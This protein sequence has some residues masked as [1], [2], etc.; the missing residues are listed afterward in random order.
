LTS[1]SANGESIQI[2]PGQVLPFFEKKQDALLGHLLVNEQF[3]MQARTKIRAEW[4]NDP[5]SGKVWKFKQNFFD[6][7]QRCPSVEEFKGTLEFLRE[8]MGMRNKLYAKITIAQV[9][10]KE[11]GLDVI[12]NELTLWL[13][14]Q[15]AKAYAEKFSQLYNAAADAD[16]ANQK[17]NEAFRVLKLGAQETEMASFELETAV[18]FDDV[19]SGTYFQK[20]QA[21]LET[22]LTF[23]CSVLDRLLNKDC[24]KEAALIR[25]DHTVLLAPTNVGKTTT[26]VTI[27]RHNVTLGRHVLFI[28]HE[29]RPDDIKTKILMAI[30]GMTYPQLVEKSLSPE[31]QQF[32]A[33][34]AAG[35][36]KYLT[37]LPMNKPGLTVEDVESAIRRAQ[38]K[39][40]AET[41]K[42][43]DLIIDDYP[44]K[45]TTVL[46]SRGHWPKRQ[47]DEHIYNFFTQIALEFNC[48]VVTA[49]Q[50]NREGSKI[51]K[52]H[53]GSE[54]RLITLEDVSESWGAMTTATNVISLN[55]DPDASARQRMTFHICKSRSND[56]GWSIVT[57]T[58]YGISLTHG[59]TYGGVTL[60]A[61]YYRGI[62]TMADTIDSLL[63]NNQYHGKSIPE[64]M[65]YA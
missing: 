57:R 31:G 5:L 25:G 30:T 63:N 51:N 48:H 55:R 21:E 47:I 53:R 49:I 22:A 46:A 8:D 43:Y 59:S 61:T 60:P 1:V 2:A 65:Y 58:N 27:L 34:A 64:H 17:F 24:L 52:G 36:K 39:R 16:D 15:T 28:T 26:M 20:K 62:S 42:G 41:G 32:L 6:R 7:Y 9:L 14:S 35:L 10:S 12:R 54:D 56:T 4:F 18:T 45:L 13:K 37:Y 33:A 3:F 19:P 44:A 50:T 11:F 29:G 38:E 23:G 40:I